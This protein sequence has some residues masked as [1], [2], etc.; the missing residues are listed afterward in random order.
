MEAAWHAEKQRQ[1]QELT[2]P[3]T[4]DSQPQP[5]HQN[6]A[7]G[8]PQS[9]PSSPP[10]IEPVVASGQ[11]P[12]QRHASPVEQQQAHHQQ[13]PIIQQ[14]QQQQRQL[15]LQQ[16][17]QQQQQQQQQRQLELQQQ[18]QQQQQQRQLEL[19]QQA[20]HQ[21]QQ[22]QQQLEQQRQLELQQQGRQ[23]QQKEE[24]EQK[25]QPELHQE[26]HRQAE[27]VLQQQQLELDQER[28]LE[29]QPP[30]SEPGDK[31]ELN[32]EQHR[33]A[34]VPSQE[35]LPQRNH[36][37]PPEA[38]HIE[39]A[40][41]ESF[42]SHQVSS[43]DKQPPDSANGENIP[44]FVQEWRSNGNKPEHADIP[45]PPAGED[46]MEKK[47]A[48]E[49]PEQ[50]NHNVPD[51]QSPAEPSP[52]E[53]IDKLEWLRKMEARSAR[54]QGLDAAASEAAASYAEPGP[55]EP[56]E[57][58]ESPPLSDTESSTAAP[59]P[60]RGIV[61]PR[62]TENEP[63]PGHINQEAA[64]E[65]DDE[66]E[67]DYKDE[68]YDESAEDDDIGED[69]YQAFTGDK[70]I[71]TPSYS[72]G[73][74][75]E[76]SSLPP[77]GQAGTISEEEWQSQDKDDPKRDVEPPERKEV[78]TPHQDTDNQ[79]HQAE[80]EPRKE[81]GHGAQA[82]DEHNSLPG[83]TLLGKMQ[84]KFARK[85]EDRARADASDSGHT[86]HDNS[87][88][89]DRPTPHAD[90]I[91][92]P[93]ILDTPSSDSSAHLP[94]GH[95]DRVVG[96][97]ADQ[98][99]ESGILSAEAKSTAGLEHEDTNTAARESETVQAEEASPESREE[100]DSIP[101][102]TPDSL[103]KPSGPLDSVQE[104]TL[105]PVES[106]S[107][108]STS[109][110]ENGATADIS[111]PN[112]GEVTDGEHSQQNEA[113]RQ[114]VHNT[115]FDGSGI[116]EV[117]DVN[118]MESAADA[119][120]SEAAGDSNQDEAAGDSNQD[121]ATG[122]SNQD[123]AAGDS[124]QDEAAGDSN[125]YEAAG[126]SNQYEAAGD[127]NQDEAAGDSN[128]DEAAGDSNQ[129]EAA[130]DSNQ[131][132]AA[133]DSNQDEAADSA[134]QRET[135]GGV[136]QAEIDDDV[137]QDDADVKKQAS[138]GD[139]G[140]VPPDV[141]HSEADDAFP[142]DP[143]HDNSATPSFSPHVADSEDQ[144]ASEQDSGSA[145]SSLHNDDH[146]NQA[147]SDDVLNSPNVDHAG[148]PQDSSTSQSAEAEVEGI[149][150]DVNSET[151]STGSTD[152]TDSSQSA[153]SVEYGKCKVVFSL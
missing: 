80:T 112:T 28:P 37:K 19:Q 122:D 100:S 69:T 107:P 54:L 121:E 33:D 151:D 50:M 103:Q 85:M 97:P 114:E 62:I 101:G 67:P 61:E 36:F 128:Q 106:E 43:E 35:V 96:S 153:T 6:E 47:S 16:Q 139:H 64:E 29:L 90:V 27:S 123:E 149:S 9:I 1:L 108:S 77:A 131:D 12:E 73:D 42:T 2:P 55:I 89:T 48:E 113:L 44:L 127:S 138:F 23:Q 56:S 119:N 31:D 109:Q 72:F 132:E 78:H 5:A 102:N 30:T 92:E 21:H 95:E 74:G 59:V 124:N 129:D 17:A 84:A 87:E 105:D 3:D 91:T 51:I 126:D 111:S 152:S 94:D 148:S 79:R 98:P 24:L 115:P 147:A 10:S 58:S 140:S 82:R 63:V 99:Y 75:V 13:E 25:R 11:E 53:S 70:D 146:S 38:G 141:S 14:Q 7:T 93:D 46:V 88:N 71:D 110:S 143:S 133:G 118:H 137:N 142:T 136:N 117:P 40:R 32:Q 60:P 68:T 52:K 65:E 45:Q 15:D 120:D 104:S 150:Q 83:T 41:T 86:P 39:E 116:G 22:H 76:N 130:G 145:E 20:Q 49:S 66:E 8:S 144:H 26:A 81:V 4:I 135:V 18:A 57:P 125:Q 34:D 134:N